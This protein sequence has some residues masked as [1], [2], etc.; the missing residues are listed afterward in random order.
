M[1]NI[2]KVISGRNNKKN[3]DSLSRKLDE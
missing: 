3:D 1:E 2:I